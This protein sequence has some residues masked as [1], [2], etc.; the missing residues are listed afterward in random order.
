LFD[1]ELP[2]LNV[3]TW[4]GRSCATALATAVMSAATVSDYDAVLNGRFK[5]GYT[6][7]H[8]GDPANG[9]HAVQLELA[10][11]T[12]MHEITLDYDRDKATKLRATLNAMLDAYEGAARR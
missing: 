11:R 7:R 12:Y 9:V 3:G 2:A 4:D 1:G 8:Y 10:Q 5:G 6:T